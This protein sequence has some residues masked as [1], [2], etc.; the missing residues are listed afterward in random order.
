MEERIGQQLLGSLPLLLVIPAEMLTGNVNNTKQ[1]LLGYAVALHHETDHRFV[2]HF[3]ERRL[4]AALSVT[5][6]VSSTIFEV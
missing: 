5:P 1:R 2:Y 6:H 3:V 4:G